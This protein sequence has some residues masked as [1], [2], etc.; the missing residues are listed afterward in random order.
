MNARR[1][2][3]RHEKTHVERGSRGRGAFD[4]TSASN[5]PIGYETTSL[6]NICWMP[7][8]NRREGSCD[9]LFAVAAV[10]V[11]QH[12]QPRSGYNGGLPTVRARTS[13]TQLRLM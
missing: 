2:V 12:P 13:E 9:L 11:G 4:I 7:P 8:F 10:A 5:L 6:L 3:R 1:S